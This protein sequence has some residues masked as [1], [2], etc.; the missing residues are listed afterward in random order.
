MQGSIPEVMQSSNGSKKTFPSIYIP[1]FF[2]R[3]SEQNQRIQNQITHIMA[4]SWAPEVYIYIETLILSADKKSIK[5]YPKF[6]PITL[7]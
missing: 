3:K 7:N 1:L 5:N 2:F 6:C 4:V